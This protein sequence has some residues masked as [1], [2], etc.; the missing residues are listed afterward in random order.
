MVTMGVEEGE[1]ALLGEEAGLG[2]AGDGFNYVEETVRVASWVGF[3][4]W[5]DV[6]F[7]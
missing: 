5:G 4:V 7:G 3:K 1:K 6:E 2:E